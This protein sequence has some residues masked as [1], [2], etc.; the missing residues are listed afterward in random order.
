[1]RG[2]I[3]L[4]GLGGAVVAGV[5]N[6]I[7]FAVAKASGANFS[8]VQGGTPTEV[9]YAMV[10]LVSAGA[11]V[12][13]SALAAL[14][15]EK[16]LRLMQIIGGVVAVLTTI[17][18]LSSTGSASAKAVLVVLHLLTGVAFVAAME[19]VRRQVPAV[20]GTHSNV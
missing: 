12:I 13:G 3:F 11:V 14:L 1:M 19:V 17:G 18:P 5:V 8:L 16:R 7:I 4:F 6:L 10:V 15:G 20:T 2:R 9:T